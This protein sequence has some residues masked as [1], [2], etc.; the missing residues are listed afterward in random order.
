[1]QKINELHAFNF[2]DPSLWL[3][4][5]TIATKFKFFTTYLCCNDSYTNVSNGVTVQ[6]IT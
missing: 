5:L 4:T 2:L 6:I 3:R 1:M